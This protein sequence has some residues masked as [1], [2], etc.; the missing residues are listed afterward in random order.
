MLRPAAVA[1]APFLLSPAAL[2]QSAWDYAPPPAY[3][4]AYS[5]A[6]PASP[7]FAARAPRATPASASAA[8]TGDRMA[9]LAHAGRV[10]VALAEWSYAPLALPQ[11]TVLRADRFGLRAG[12]APAVFDGEGSPCAAVVP[13]AVGPDMARAFGRFDAPLASIGPETLG[14]DMPVPDAAIVNPTYAAQF[15]RP[16]PPVWVR[17][18]VMPPDVLKFLLDNAPQLPGEPLKGMSFQALVNHPYNPD[19]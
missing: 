10:T 5:P 4:P 18:G 15:R 17:G 1:L 19:T 13:A 9:T 11:R 2:A 12:L 3:A 16:R 8:P 6:S 14:E 7:A